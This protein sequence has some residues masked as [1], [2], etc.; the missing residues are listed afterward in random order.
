MNKFLLDSNICI[1]LLRK[2][3]EVIE[4]MERVGWSN[5]CISELTVV[6]LFYGAECSSNPV[7]NKKAVA[8]FLNDMEIIPFRT[9]IKEFCRQKARLRRMG[10]PI[11]D[12]DLYIGTTAVAM[13]YILVTENVRHLSRLENIRLEN[14][15]IRES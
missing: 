3:K 5:C 8:S 10:T 9:C 6:E 1:H 13:D 7:R 4:A 14:W 11:E 15:I 2:R 12:T